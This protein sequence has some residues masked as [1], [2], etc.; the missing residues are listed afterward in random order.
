MSVDEEDV[1]E[2]HSIAPAMSAVQSVA[3]ASKQRRLRAILRII[4]QVGYVKKSLPGNDASERPGARMGGW[5]GGS[6]AGQLGSGGVRRG[7]T[8]G[9]LR[10]DVMILLRRSGDLLQRIVAPR[11]SSRNTA[12]IRRNLQGGASNTQ[13]PSTLGPRQETV[14]WLGLLQ[15][16]PASALS[17]QLARNTTL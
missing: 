9:S 17:T 5:L 4:L 15:A 1:E 12:R 7:R 6:W 2:L 13:C 11:Q 16:L 8:H 10:H 3:S 14:S